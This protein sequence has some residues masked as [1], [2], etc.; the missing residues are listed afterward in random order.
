MV[1]DV[2]IGKGGLIGRERDAPWLGHAAAT[3]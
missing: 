1:R 3:E 2:A